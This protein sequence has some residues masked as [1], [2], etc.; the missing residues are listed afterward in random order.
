[1]AV[2]QHFWYKNGEGHNFYHDDWKE[3]L[4]PAYAAQIEIAATISCTASQA[5]KR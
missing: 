5:S 3:N 4:L 1:M 2:L